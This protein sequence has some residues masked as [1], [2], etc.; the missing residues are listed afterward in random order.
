MVQIYSFFAEFAACFFNILIWIKILFW[1]FIL[2]SILFLVACFFVVDV[3]KNN[4]KVINVCTLAFSAAL[5][6]CMSRG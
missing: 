4:N 2:C 1:N 6:V 3:F 5:N